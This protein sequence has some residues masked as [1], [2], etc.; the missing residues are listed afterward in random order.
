MG[1]CQFYVILGNSS[2]KPD[3]SNDVYINISDNELVNYKE[4]VKKL[5]DL[6]N[7]KYQE[8]IHVNNR[9]IFK[10]FDERYRNAVLKVM[11]IT[12]IVGDIEYNQKENNSVNEVSNY[13]YEE[14]KPNNPVRPDTMVFHGD[15]V[16]DG[17]TPKSYSGNGISKSKSNVKSLKKSKRA[18]IVSLP[19]LIF[20]LST[21]L[22]VASFV[23][24]FILD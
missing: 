1:N 14:K 21:L 5:T 18:G 11:D 23:L 17:G 22:L 6:Y 10:I 3:N 24:L 19:V 7:Q 20:I 13:S 16:S 12:G 9:I 8:N 4:L 15:F 2:Y